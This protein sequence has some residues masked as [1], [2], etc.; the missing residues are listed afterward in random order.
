MS[1]RHAFE[2]ILAPAVSIERE[3]SDETMTDF[4]YDPSRYPFLVDALDIVD[5]ACIKSGQG[6]RRQ[7]IVTAFELCDDGLNVRA[8]AQ[9]LEDED[10]AV[11]MADIQNLLDEGKVDFVNAVLISELP[12]EYVAT[13]FYNQIAAQPAPW[14]RK[15]A[16]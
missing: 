6:P 4:R 14:R 12:T 2:T 10:G 3:S 8:L 1:K 5:A 7:H 15:N 13:T 11:D 16:A 9:R